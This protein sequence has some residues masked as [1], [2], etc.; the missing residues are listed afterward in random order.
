MAAEVARRL[1][2]CGALWMAAAVADFRP[3]KA[4]RQK[5]SKRAGAPAIP[6]VPTEDVL[7]SAGRR[8]RKGQILVG[9]A[10]ETRDLLKNA[11]SKLREKNVDFVVANDVT[12]RGAGFESERNAVTVL[13]RT[14]PPLKLGL[15]SKE[16]I[17]ERLVDLVHGAEQVRW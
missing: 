2:G 6:W 12:L 16:E 3:E 15:S 1:P 13:S 7:A 10:A 17:A 14:R 8:R 4:V 11:R 9:F 5:L